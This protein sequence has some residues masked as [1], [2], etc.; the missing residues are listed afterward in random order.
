MFSFS[1]LQFLN[2]DVVADGF[3]GKGLVLDCSNEDKMADIFRQAQK[4]CK[5]GHSVLI[6]CMIGKTNFRKGSISVW[7]DW[8]LIISSLFKQTGLISFF[9]KMCLDCV[10][11]RTH[12]PHTHTHTHTYIQT[13]TQVWACTHTPTHTYK[14]LICHAVYTSWQKCAKMLL[15][16]CVL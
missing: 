2:Y 16:W 15:C 5:E 6:N 13:K 10:M 8:T 11:L 9:V 3:G 14:N 1:K 4:L 12:T 7:Y